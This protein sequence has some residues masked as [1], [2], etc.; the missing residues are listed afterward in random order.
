MKSGYTLFR[1]TD[2]IN[3]DE[4][5]RSGKVT[6]FRCLYYQFLSDGDSSSGNTANKKV[7]S[8]NISLHSGTGSFS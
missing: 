8:F 5:E 2:N 1:V 6:A 3:E 7:F 4:N